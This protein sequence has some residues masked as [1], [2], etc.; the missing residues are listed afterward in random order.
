[1]PFTHTTFWGGL[2]VS[3]PCRRRDGRFGTA[4]TRAKPQT[5]QARR[6]ATTSGTRQPIA[7]EK[8]GLGSGGALYSFLNFIGLTGLDLL[9][10][11]CPDPRLKVG[12]PL[13]IAGELYGCPGNLIQSLT[14]WRAYHPGDGFPTAGWPDISVRPTCWCNRTNATQVKGPEVAY[15]FNKPMVVTD[16]GGG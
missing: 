4:G 5:F 6:C 13:I 14:A 15:H 7:R 8:A 11:A 12:H 2:P 3:S 9:L 16:V 1:M 10:Q